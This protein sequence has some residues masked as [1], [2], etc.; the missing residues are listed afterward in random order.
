M[1]TFIHSHETK[2]KKPLLVYKNENPVESARLNLS[3]VEWSNLVVGSPKVE[4]E[5]SLLARA[6]VVKRI[7]ALVG[8]VSLA[9]RDRPLV[10]TMEN[11]KSDKNT[12]ATNE[13]ALAPFD[14]D[15]ATAVVGL[16]VSDVSIGITYVSRGDGP[17]PHDVVVLTALVDSAD[18]EHVPI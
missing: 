12:I 6:G 14:V 11:T 16:S 10:S 8:G 4:T 3:K 18:T 13:E 1:G 15:A 5:T 17:L 7:R 9:D 2:L